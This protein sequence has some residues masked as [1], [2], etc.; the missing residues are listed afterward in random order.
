MTEEFDYLEW[1]IGEAAQMQGDDTEVYAL[2][3][4]AHALPGIL[5][6]LRIN[7][8][9]QVLNV[10]YSGVIPSAQEE[11]EPTSNG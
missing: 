3:A 9:A 1:A 10:H 4:I 6:Q 5:Q 2:R 11:D 8:A 7:A